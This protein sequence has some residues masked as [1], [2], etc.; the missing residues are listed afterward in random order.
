MLKLNFQIKC[1]Y[2]DYL[3]KSPIAELN[4]LTYAELSKE[5]TAPIA[6]SL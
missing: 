5:G 1:F 3:T 6:R 2:F 4:T